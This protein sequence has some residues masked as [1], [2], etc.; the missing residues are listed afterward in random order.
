MNTPGNNLSN[1]PLEQRARALY[2][3]AARDLD[4]AIAGRLRAARRDVLAGTR[5]AQ[6]RVARWLVPSGACA[7]IAL[8]ALLVWPSA[9]R[10]TAEM[11]A[12]VTA[13]AGNEA[14]S[15]LPPDPEQADPN[16]YQNL[17]FY[18]WLAANDNPPP[19]H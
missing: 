3:E 17:D 7:A 19:A 1:A 9:P 8:A 18:G 2:H 15:P 12:A 5:Q 10:P 14:D 11:P 16:L 13:A 6:H 4:P